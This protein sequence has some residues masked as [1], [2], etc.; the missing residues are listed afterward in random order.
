MCVY[1]C[2]EVYIC[3]YQYV[4]LSVQINLYSFVLVNYY[5]RTNFSPVMGTDTYLLT[6]QMAPFYGWGLTVSR[7]QPHYKETVYILPLR[8][9]EFDL[10]RMK[11]GVDLEATLQVLD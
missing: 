8:L 9:E 10:G 1:L 5:L 3:I 4:V 6:Y 11:G 2:F 7:L